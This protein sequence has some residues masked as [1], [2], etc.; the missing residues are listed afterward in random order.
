M[1]AEPDSTLLLNSMRE[2]EFVPVRGCLTLG[3]DAGL[4]NSSR[5]QKKIHFCH[6]RCWD[7]I[8]SP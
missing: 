7:T 4:K 6:V 2:T 8:R 5:S 1:G 3:M